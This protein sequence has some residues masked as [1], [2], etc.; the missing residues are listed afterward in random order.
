MNKEKLRSLVQLLK[1]LKLTRLQLVQ[2]HL[3]HWKAANIFFHNDTHVN[4]FHYIY[5]FKLKDNVF[6]FVYPITP[7]ISTCA[8]SKDN[9]N[10]AIFHNEKATDISTCACVQPLLKTY[11][12]NLIQYDKLSKQNKRM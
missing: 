3:A 1:M 9:Q 8:Y 5:M 10:L 4:L 7:H 12:R 2:I 11:I 6:Q